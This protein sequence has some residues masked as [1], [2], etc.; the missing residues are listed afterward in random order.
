MVNVKLIDLGPN[1]DDVTVLHVEVCRSLPVR[2]FAAIKVEAHLTLGGGGHLGHVLGEDG[3]QRSISV[4][5][6]LLRGV[7]VF[8]LQPHSQAAA[9]A[10]LCGAAIF[11]CHHHTLDDVSDAKAEFADGGVRW[12]LLFLSQQHEARGRGV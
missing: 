12:E 5:R 6:E 8:A 10:A 7:S 2:H 3:A 9:A 11:C 1:F 4:Q